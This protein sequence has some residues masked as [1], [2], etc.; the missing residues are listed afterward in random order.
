[1]DSI[2]LYGAPISPFVRKVRLAL[3]HKGLDYQLVPVMPIGDDLPIEFTANSPLG[4]IPLMNAGELWL[5]DSSVI[6][7]WLERA[8]PEQPLLSDDAGSAA[9][10]LWYE[11]YADSHISGVVGLHLFAEIVLAPLFFKR[12]PIQ[13]D[14]DTAMNVELPQ[15]FDYLEN[16]LNDAYLL[17]SSISLAD[18]SVGCMFVS[19]LH[20]DKH[21]DSGRWPK[22]ATYIDKL[23]TSDLFAP[24]IEEEKQMLSAMQ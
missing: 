6:C 9:R 11:E 19:M 12:E 20:C 13:A 16:E 7:A 24:I 23:M 15:I 18:I 5:P 17:G 4:K 2:T 22:V 3:K 8:Y 10:A 14:I 21:C 1:M